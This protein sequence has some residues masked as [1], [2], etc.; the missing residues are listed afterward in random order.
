MSPTSNAPGSFMPTAGGAPDMGASRAGII[1]TVMG[2]V[3]ATA[4]LMAEPPSS[5]LAE[6]LLSMSFPA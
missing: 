6:Y 1:S 5:I 4:E 3:M 2:S